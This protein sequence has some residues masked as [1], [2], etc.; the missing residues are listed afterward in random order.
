[1]SPRKPRTYVFVED[2]S[3]LLPRLSARD[4]VAARSGRAA[5]IPPRSGVGPFRPFRRRRSFIPAQWRWWI[6]FTLVLL[7][8]GVTAHAAWGDP[9][10]ETSLPADG[11]TSIERVGS[12]WTIVTEDPAWEIKI[13]GG[14]TICGHNYGDDCTLSESFESSDQCVYLQVD[15]AGLYGHNSSDPYVC[16]PGATETLS[17]TPTPSIVPTTSPTPSETVTATP[18]PEPTCAPGDELWPSGDGTYVCGPADEP[19]PG[20]S[21]PTSGQLPVTGDR[22]ALVL[23]LACAILDA[24][25][26]LIWVN[27]KREIQRYRRSSASAPVIADWSVLNPPMQSEKDVDPWAHVGPRD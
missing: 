13:N 4:G 24:G 18:A 15:W 9:N 8:L 7:F 10:I 5:T 16:R 23:L 17:P 21:D 14:A 3:A 20:D 22:L 19:N 12:T 25:L 1:M 11:V 26:W 2:R 6:V 27:H